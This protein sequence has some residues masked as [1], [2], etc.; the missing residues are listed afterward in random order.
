MAAPGRVILLSGPPDPES[1]SWDDANLLGDFEGPLAR[2]L[3]GASIALE[4]TD[5]TELTPSFHLAKWRSV[6]YTGPEQQYLSP[7]GTEAGQT[8]FLSFA[9][10][11]PD[12]ELDNGHSEFLDHSV[13]VLHDIAS[14]QIRPKSTG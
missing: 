5:S 10:S 8:Q 14:S 7:Q 2:F 11:S 13:A 12:A 9:T 3:D 4:S 6:E 1:L